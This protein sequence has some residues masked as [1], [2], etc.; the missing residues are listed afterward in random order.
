M[1][2]ALWTYDWV[3]IPIMYPQLVFLAVSA[4]GGPHRLLS[5]QVHVYF[6]LCLFTRQFI[7]RAEA[8]NQTE[9][10]SLSEE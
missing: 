4:A 9:V 7:I 8:V 5:L 2:S 1:L 10:C 6:F 3:P